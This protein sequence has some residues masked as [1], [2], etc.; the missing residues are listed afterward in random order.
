MESHEVVVPVFVVDKTG[1]LLPGAI[2]R[3]LRLKWRSINR[4][5]EPIDW[6]CKRAIRRGIIGAEGQFVSGVLGFAELGWGYSANGFLAG[7]RRKFHDLSVAVTESRSCSVK[8][9]LR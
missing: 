2:S 7:E 4:R 3:R 9:M 1:R 5:Q 6:K 8:G